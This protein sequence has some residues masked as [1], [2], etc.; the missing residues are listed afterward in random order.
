MKNFKFSLVFVLLCSH[1]VTFATVNVSLH[2]VVNDSISIEKCDLCVSDTS[3]RVAFFAELSEK[4]IDFQLQQEGNY[5]F[6]LTDGPII[7]CNQSFVIEGD[8]TLTLEQEARS[9]N[10]DEV[11]IVAQS[12][13]QTTATGQIFK[14]SDTARKSGDPFKALS[15]IPLLNVDISGQSVKTNEGDSPVIL[16]NGKFVNSGIAPIDPKFIESVEIVEVVNAKYLQMGVSKI[17]DIHLKRNVPLYT[18]VDFRTRHDIPLREGFGAANFEV[19]TSKYAIS[20]NLSGDYMRNDKVNNAISEASGN[21]SRDLDLN[22]KSRSLGYDGQLLLKWI[23][24]PTEYFAGVMKKRMSYNRKKGE[25][26]G[27]YNN[28]DYHTEQNNRLDEGGWLGAVYYEHSFNDDSRFSAFAKYNRGKYNEEDRRNDV[29]STDVNS[30]ERKYW[31]FEKSNRNQYTLTIDYDGAEHDYGNIS[32]GNN[33]VHTND[34]NYDQTVNPHDKAHVNL[35]SNYSYA[36]Y[37]KMCKRLFVM[38]S[39][40][41]QYMHIQTN[42]GSNS[43]WRPRAVATVGLNLP[44]SQAVRLIY[45]LDNELPLSSQLST[46]NHS[47]NPWMKIEGNPYLVPMEKHGVTLMYDKTFSKFTTRL[48]TEYKQHKN[49]IEKFITNDGDYSI[50]SYR[51]NGS[52]HNYRVG[53]IFTFRT[54]GFRATFRCNWQQEKYYHASSNDIVELGGNLKW[55]FGKFF[56]YS[57]ILWKNKSY[58]AVCQTTYQNPSIAHVQVAWQTTKSLYISAGLPYFWGVRAEKTMTN[59]G[60]YSNITKTRFKS[61]SL[62]P[63]IL[64]SW[65]I[66]KNTSQSIDDRMPNY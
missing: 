8:T 39:I 2:I 46:F 7:V 65:T 48:F 35:V 14:L 12:R 45:N 53:G 26:H 58:T 22:S 42:D 66:R 28:S 20:G 43:W 32:G 1:L 40:G 15:E 36:S 47:T 23:P 52:W 61:S 3:N 62:R 6:I 57:D 24:K 38:G 16:V 13:P 29:Y 37:S 51:N 56:V 54:N 21:N 64:I 18:F 59:Q 49:M 31:E 41:L 11:V 10:L 50:Q 9:I 5:T 33:F 30:D 44:Q 17:I 63:W 34:A 4:H 55:D 19:G 25:G 60:D 27:V